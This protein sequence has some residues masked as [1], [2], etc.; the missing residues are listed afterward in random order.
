MDFAWGLPQE[1][2]D[3]L[4]MYMLLLFAIEDKTNHG[5][6]TVCLALACSRSAH[7]GQH[8]HNTTT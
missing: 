7:Y 3:L 4:S 1:L 5:Q 2:Y 8:D 6:P